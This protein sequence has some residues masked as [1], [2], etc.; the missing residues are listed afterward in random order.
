MAPLASWGAVSFGRIQMIWCSWSLDSRTCVCRAIESSS[1]YY[2]SGLI[3]CY[4]FLLFLGLTRSLCKQ[5][6][7]RPFG[8]I[9]SVFSSDIWGW[10]AVRN[11]R[12]PVVLV[13]C[14]FKCIFRRLCL[15]HLS[16]YLC[17]FQCL[18]NQSQSEVVSSL[19]VEWIVRCCLVLV[20]CLTSY[21]TFLVCFP[22]E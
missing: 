10:P 15:H 1:V 4:S 3:L 11:A 8:L 19:V 5:T 20:T 7:L 12:V 22:L 9:N 14:V 6:R 2:R 17:V 16:P 21:L 18:V 13:W